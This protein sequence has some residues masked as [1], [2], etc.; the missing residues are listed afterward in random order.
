MADLDIK[1][2]EKFQIGKPAELNN[3]PSITETS[4]VTEATEVPSIV[5]VS[6]HLGSK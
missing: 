4:I 2:Y 5:V 3:V 1:S 6:L